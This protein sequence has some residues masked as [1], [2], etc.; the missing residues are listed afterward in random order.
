M[1]EYEFVLYYDFF[2]NKKDKWYSVKLIKSEEEAREK[3][4]IKGSITVLQAWAAFEKTAYYRYIY[5]MEK[6]KYRQQSKR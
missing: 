6:R 4:G 3:T 5:Q 1:K 2:N